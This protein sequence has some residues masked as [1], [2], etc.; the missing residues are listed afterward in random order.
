MITAGFD[1][2]TRVVKACI[3]DDGKIT[4]WSKSTLDDRIDKVINKTYVSALDNAGVKKGKVEKALATGYCSEMMSGK[5]R[6]VSEALCISRAAHS[7]DKKIRTVIDIGGLS[8]NIIIIDDNG[9]VQET[10]SN[11]RCAAGSG[12]FL[13]MVSEATE[14]PMDS[15]SSSVMKSGR[16]CNIKSNCAVFAESEVISRINSGHSANDIIASVL[17]SIASRAAILLEKIS[18]PDDMVL[19][20]GVSK[21]GVLRSI[22]EELVARKIAELPADSQIIS[23]F[24]AALI[25]QGKMI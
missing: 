24:G 1:I 14:I 19:I 12:K 2:G 22:L 4:G 17:Y 3:V 7:F 21:I 15:I 11:D 25:A 13:E 5:I 18:A 20:G 9:H 16:P 8:I 6:P 23:A 10:I